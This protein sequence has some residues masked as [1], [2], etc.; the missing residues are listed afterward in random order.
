MPLTLK[1]EHARVRGDLSR[2]PL[3]S[4]PANDSSQHHEEDCAQARKNEKTT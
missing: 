2:R 3:F 1:N 4:L